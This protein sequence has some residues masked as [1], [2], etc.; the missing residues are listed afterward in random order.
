[1]TS[2]YNIYLITIKL[3]FETNSLQKKGGVVNEHHKVLSYYKY[4]HGYS[5]KTG[6]CELKNYRLKFQTIH[7]YLKN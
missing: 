5:V 1:M 6:F 2:E 3:L 4:R 7:L